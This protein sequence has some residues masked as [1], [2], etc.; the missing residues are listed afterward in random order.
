[1]ENSNLSSSDHTQ[2]E[3]ITTSQPQTESTVESVDTVDTIE[4]TEVTEQA[5]ATEVKATESLGSLEPELSLETSLETSES[6]E[7]HKE[8]LQSQTII[9]SSVEDV[10]HDVEDTPTSSEEVV[11]NDVD[12]ALTTVGGDQIPN[13][14][15]QQKP[16]TKPRQQT[17]FDNI[18]LDV[19]T[20]NRTFCRNRGTLSQIVKSFSDMKTRLEAPSNEYQKGLYPHIQS[21]CDSVV[22]EY[23]S[24]VGSINPSDNYVFG[25]YLNGPNNDGKR[26][27]T[28][29][30]HE[31]KTY[32][33]SEFKETLRSVNDRLRHI[34]LTC[35][36][37]VNESTRVD[38][39]VFE[40]MVKFCDDF[41]TIID[42][43]LTRWNDFIDNFRKAN[44][45]VV[46]APL[47]NDDKNSQKSK[48]KSQ[49]SNRRSQQRSKSK[50]RPRPNT[51]SG[52]NTRSN[53]Q[54]RPN[55]QSRSNTQTRPTAQTRINTQSRN[56]NGQ[57]RT[58]IHPR[59][60]NSQ[61]QVQSQSQD[62]R[63]GSPTRGGGRRNAIFVK[64]TSRRGTSRKGSSIKGSG[65]A[66]STSRKGVP[67]NNQPKPASK[68]VTINT[69]V[70]E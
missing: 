36:K 33:V 44:G 21:E 35:Q 55:T 56:S 24:L 54:T 69:T 47:P 59:S 26:K 34:K 13:K 28:T 22:N 52:P 2:N 46:K 68:R 45:I 16:Q 1:M 5:V 27:A 12:I 17:N 10:P 25:F 61:V 32:G 53:T 30:P 70:D 15:T 31:L 38:N 7:N 18:T 42:E 43:K 67:K 64:G 48:S 4:S 39:E 50:S 51:Q 65:T 29:T 3:T 9:D 37:K 14:D 66:R 49:Q 19:V 11:N 41:H 8:D 6:V 40:R 23:V 63:S 20:F 57:T 60:S 62:Q 58:N